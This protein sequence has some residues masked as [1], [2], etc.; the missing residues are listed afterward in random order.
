MW[1]NVD[2]VVYAAGTGR[3]GAAAPV[4]EW[5]SL[6][7][8]EERAA[9]LNLTYALLISAPE[10]KISTIGGFPPRIGGF[11]SFPA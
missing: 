3:R 6:S 8:T 9:V 1:L 5:P 2:G 10:N 11:K 7:L 4:L